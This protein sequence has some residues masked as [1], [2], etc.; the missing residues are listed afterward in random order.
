MAEN[1]ALN[2]S[3]Q[4][5][6]QQASED[7]TA[8]SVEPRIHLNGHRPAK[9]EEVLA[10]H[11]TSQYKPN[12]PIYGFRDEYW[13]GPEFFYDVE[14][15][16]Q[17]DSITTPLE[18]VMAPLSQMQVSA[19]GSSNKVI[20]FLLDEW[21]KF[22]EQW[23][24]VVQYPGYSYG[25]MGAE[26]RYDVE[27]GM[28]V[29]NEFHDFAPRDA[30]PLIQRNNVVGVQVMS[31]SSD[32]GKLLV[33][34]GIPCKGFWYAHKPVYGR[35]YGQSQIRR[36]WKPWRRLTGRDGLEEVMDIA[37]HRYGTGQVVVRA[38]VGDIKATNQPAGQARQSMMERARE[39]AESIKA[40]GAIALPSEVDAG[41]KY[42]W[43]L[44]SFQPDMKLTELIQGSEYLEKKCSKAI[45]FPPELLEAAETGSGFSG[46]M[47]PLQG[48]LMAQQ[49]VAQGLFYAWFTQI[50]EPLVRWNFGPNAWVKCKVVPLLK[51]YRQASQGA[52]QPAGQVGASP[53]PGAQPQPGP[54]QA[55]SES[56]P[57]PQPNADGK[58]PYSG[59][60]GG[61]GWRDAQGRVHYGAMMSTDNATMN[62][63]ARSLENVVNGDDAER[64]L[65][66]LVKLLPNLEPAELD[67]LAAAVEESDRPA[68][69][70]VPQ[71]PN[72]LTAAD[73]RREV[74]A[75]LGDLLTPLRDQMVMLSTQAR[76]PQQPSVV[77]VT[78]PPVHVIS[79]PVNIAPAQVHVA[80]A[81]V[82]I[83]P[84]Q[85]SLSTSLP[86]RIADKVSD[87]ME[88]MHKHQQTANA[89]MQAGQARTAEAL[90]RLYDGL[91]KMPAPV[92]NVAAQDAPVVNV[93]QQMQPIVNVAAP[94]VRVVIPE[95]G[96]TRTTPKYDKDGRVT[97]VVKEPIGEQREPTVEIT[98][99][100]VEVK[101]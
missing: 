66:R 64:N 23:L 43:D 10:S 45:G 16:L 84:Q 99:A 52:Q 41:G 89:E 48:F 34:H 46:R 3:T 47:I 19:K 21:T 36:A 50:G 26:V 83:E 58:I 17:H 42:K 5:P 95:Q 82:N 97:E 78:S 98:P 76:Q 59:P 87:T 44:D 67:A 31:L 53:Q 37:V 32:A 96:P 75:A 92:V 25:W 14:P 85:I 88:A 35:H 7:T 20:T 61:V 65:N 49:H 2:G 40:G 74:V 54:A 4:T 73:V 94:I 30:Q 24:P 86:E 9:V 69:V 13:I 38:P 55:T 63:A 100:T 11:Q 68:I 51:S 90:E 62:R 72:T 80:P 57:P 56:V 28:L 81:Q 33:P 79:P 18:Y 91:A 6:R 60:R 29:Q 77:N 15:M 27:R 93:P 101:S 70:D 1:G 71:V 39:M 22:K 8:P 12:L